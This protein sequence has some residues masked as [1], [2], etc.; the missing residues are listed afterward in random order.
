[1]PTHA[2]TRTHTHTHTHTH[3]LMH[4]LTHTHTRTH[5]HMHTCTHAHM[6]THTCTRTH[7]GLLA[8]SSSSEAA[9]GGNQGHL[10][11]DS[12]YSSVDE[13]DAA[14]G[15]VEA[16]DGSS[17]SSADAYRLARKVQSGYVSTKKIAVTPIRGRLSARGSSRRRQSLK[18][19]APKSD[20][21]DG[22]SS[23]GSQEKSSVQA[24]S[25]PYVLTPICLFGFEKPS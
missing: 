4:T 8:A 21:G 6:H 17:L 5:S 10:P 22:G 15:Y 2:Y 11:Y 25:D 12:I 14:T 7:L 18:K 3:T 23:A 9:Q 20:G 19:K 1:V 16:S 13:D 24:A